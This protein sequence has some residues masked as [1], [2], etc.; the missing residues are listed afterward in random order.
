MILRKYQ[1]GNKFILPL[2]KT[3]SETTNVL[4][5]PIQYQ[6]NKEIEHKK[7]KVQAKQQ[8]YKQL[9]RGT[10]SQNQYRKIIKSIDN[11]KSELNDKLDPTKSREKAEQLLQIATKTPV[12]TNKSQYQDKEKEKEFF[13]EIEESKKTSLGNNYITND[14]LP[15]LGRAVVH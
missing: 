3:K 4:N 2:D 10:I 5:G 8:A 13:D 11:S 9:E 14:I 7:L 12:I 6:K 1:T 15:N